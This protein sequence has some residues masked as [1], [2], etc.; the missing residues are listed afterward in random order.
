M[1]SLSRLLHAKFKWELFPLCYFKC[2]NI[3]IKTKQNRQRKWYYM[4]AYHY[5]PRCERYSSVTKKTLFHF[6]YLL[7]T[8]LWNERTLLFIHLINFCSLNYVLGRKPL[9]FIKKTLLFKYKCVRRFLRIKY[10]FYERSF[11]YFMYKYLFK[12]RFYQFHFDLLN[13]QFICILFVN[14]CVCSHKRLCKNYR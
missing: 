10:F 11:L 8:R 1:K 7:S 12:I 6:P 14:V 4:N 9:H 3:L 2:G 13:E 5:Y